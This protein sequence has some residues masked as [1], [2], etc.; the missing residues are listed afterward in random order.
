MEP[1]RARRVPTRATRIRRLLRRTVVAGL[2][3]LVVGLAVGLVSGGPSVVASVLLVSGLVVMIVAMIAY[4]MV[5][6]GEVM[7][8]DR[9]KPGGRPKP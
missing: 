7:I 8:A 1:V 9:P 6:W 4:R 2:L 3:L 5:F